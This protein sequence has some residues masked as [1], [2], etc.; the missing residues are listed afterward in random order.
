MRTYTGY[1]AILI[2]FLNTLSGAPA[3][4]LTQIPP[5][6]S[7]LVAPVPENG[8]WT[9]KIKPLAPE[10]T[11]EQKK[12]NEESG[13][14]FEPLPIGAKSGPGGIVELRSEKSGR[15][16]KDMATY[17]K[18]PA[19]EFWFFDNYVLTKRSSGNGYAVLDAAS[20]LA[21]SPEVSGVL[22]ELGSL[23]FSPGFPGVKWLQMKHYDKVVLWNKTRPCYHYILRGE[24]AEDGKGAVVAEAWIDART[25]LPV[26]Y[27]AGGVLY[28]YEF[29]D[30][31]S[32][33][34]Q[35]PPEAVEAMK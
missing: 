30:P 6:K 13:V 31:P 2:G 18:R 10:T 4:D 7:P 21:M 24:S 34:L 22:R 29:G 32:P 25:G 5:P 19:K 33:P 12:A 3:P 17:D 15:I 11:E 28:T 23:V 20:V 26:S 14:A 9:I 1:L 16:K 27:S 35:L 8:K